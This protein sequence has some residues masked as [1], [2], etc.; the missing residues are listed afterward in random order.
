MNNFAKKSLCYLAW[1]AS[2]SGIGSAEAYGRHSKP[3]VEVWPG[4][5]ESA[6]AETRL[7]P[8][9]LGRG[10]TLLDL[11]SMDAARGADWWR[12]YRPKN[13]A[14]IRL[15]E[16]DFKRPDFLAALADQYMQL[17][18]DYGQRVGDLDERLRLEQR[19]G[20][21]A[22]TAELATRKREQEQRTDEWLIGALKI[23][24]QLHYV[25]EYKNYSGMDTVLANM[26]VLLILLKKTKN[27]DPI[28]DRLQTEYPRSLSVDLGK[29]AL[30]ELLSE[31]KDYQ[32]ALS[33]Y[34]RI[35][36]NQ[37]AK[38]AGYALYKSG[39][40]YY[41]LGDYSRALTAF[42]QAIERAEGEP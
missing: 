11:V 14:E 34:K 6:K 3:E 16:Q 32:G 10:C 42:A 4:A 25:P 41:A 7:A 31:Q 15:G 23:Y 30:A 8:T 12:F 9:E 29:L 38:Y 19:R 33:I 1:V 39:R 2:V 13:L 26:A 20:Q 35:A 22:R 36:R 27:L 37:N 28:L 18:Q 21:L 40:I 5:S 17:A 24:A